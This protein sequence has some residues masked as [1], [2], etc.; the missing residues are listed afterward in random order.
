MEA[1]DTKKGEKLDYKDMISVALLH[2]AN[3]GEPE[4]VF[5]SILEGASTGLEN[6]SKYCKENL[7][8]HKDVKQEA[9]LYEFI[10]ISAYAN[11]VNMILMNSIASV[12]KDPVLKTFMFF[13]ATNLTAAMHVKREVLT[14]E[15]VADLSDRIALLSPQTVGE[16]LGGG[17]SA[18]NKPD[19]AES[20]LMDKSLPEGFM[21]DLSKH[22]DA[23]KHKEVVEK[24]G[25]LFSKLN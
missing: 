4:K 2:I 14:Q 23:E 6:L 9:I 5:E 7:A 15:Q 22:F 11:S 13:A 8:C 1:A 3:L 12:V 18:E 17:R 25:H 16:L 20:D 21:E 19:A 24:M 10:K